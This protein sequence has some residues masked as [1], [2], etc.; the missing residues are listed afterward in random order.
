[1]KKWPLEKL[2]VKGTTDF[3]I[4]SARVTRHILA[5]LP[6]FKVQHQIV[7][8]RSFDLHNL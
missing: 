4:H 5:D 2:C 6:T 1:M 8:L 7:I 3:E